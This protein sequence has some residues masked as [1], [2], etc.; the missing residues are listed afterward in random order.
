MN[1]LIEQLINGLTLGSQYALVAAGLAL[2]FG[3][4]EIVNFAHGELVMI[5]AYLL[6]A[7]G[8][9]LD[10]PYP[11]A[12]VTTVAAMA[13]VGA[14]F[15]V[16]VIRRILE[17]GWQVQLVATLAVSIVLINLAIVVEGS[18]PKVA[19]SELGT[20]TVTIAGTQ[21]SVQRFVVLL[22]MAATFGVLI[23]FLRST[24]TGRAMR[25]LA[26]NREAAAVVGIPVQRIGLVT[27]VIASC[28]AGIAAATMTPLYSA[29]PTM[30]TLLAIKA[31]AAVIMGGFGNVSGA[32]V[33]GFAL[34]IAEALAIGY[35]S[36]AYADVLVF[37]VMIAV[38][39][40]RPHGLF[41]RAVRA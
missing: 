36:S 20:R 15:Y 21:V 25:A 18:L 40:V 8:T 14:L 1:G 16:T 31:F 23:W 11:L 22:S 7:A 6:H 35:V 32:V 28:M 5:G 38:L 34:G 37:S 2:I 29:H 30:G 39:L 27:V 3:V 33:S 17:R 9:Y 19:Y 13:A 4:L 41:G 12:A 24:R 26:Q 10:L